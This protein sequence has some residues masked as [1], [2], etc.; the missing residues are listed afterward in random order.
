MSANLTLRA[1]DLP[2]FDRVLE[3]LQKRGEQLSPLMARIGQALESSTIERFDDER[4]P[5]GSKWTQSIRA[6]EEGGKTLTKS[7]RLKQSITH[8]VL[9]DDRVEIGTNVKYAGAHQEGVSKGVTVKAHKRKMSH[10]F[11]RKLLSPKEV[12]VGSF[13][14]DMNLPARPFLGV[15]ADDEDEIVAQGEDYLGEVLP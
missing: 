6:R 10:I 7:A 5:D 14:R 4:T 11:G 9:G 15:S 12:I 1:V 2:R 3:Q 8:N 13:A